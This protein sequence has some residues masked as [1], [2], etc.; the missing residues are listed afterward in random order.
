MERRSAGA[1]VLFTILS[2]VTVGWW[3]LAFWPAGAPS[4][5]LLERTRDVCFGTSATGLP[6]SA[7]WMALI[8]QPTI[9]F[10][11]FFIITGRAFEEAIR[12]V[13]A[14]PFGRAAVAGYVVLVF[15]GVSGVG[16]RLAN[17]SNLRDP[18]S[19]PAS[20]APGTYPRLDR[21]APVFA[22]LDQHGNT[23]GMEDFTGRAVIVTFAFG[24]CE[25]VC[26]AV[27]HDA[28]AAIARRPE[29]NAALMVISLDPWRDVPSR[30]TSLAEQWQLGSDDVALSGSVSDVEAA[31]DAWRV[32]RAR[33]TRTGDV[34]HP[35]LAYLVDAE[36]TIAYAITGGVDQMMA[37]LDR[38]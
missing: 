30:L 27:V 13:T 22:L 3:A 36:G 24:H 16:V 14:R 12:S 2:V 21:E 38:L 26:P 9:M 28:R 8:L 5:E 17:A 11:L 4:G 35:R 18:A 23:V 25:T 34:V 7:G 33:D 1:L 10:G 19:V 6:D 37:L 29:S 20:V 15:A 31:L 32:P